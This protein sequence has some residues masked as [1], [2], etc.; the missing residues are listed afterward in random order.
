MYTSNVSLATHDIGGFSNCE[1]EKGG[2][3]LI[4]H[5]LP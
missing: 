5:V 4:F 1:G 3:Y 2:V